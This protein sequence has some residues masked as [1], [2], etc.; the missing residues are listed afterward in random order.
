MEASV[1]LAKIKMIEDGI[2]PAMTAA[3]L[4]IMLSEMNEQEKKIAKRK[5]RKIWRKIAKNP[6]YARSMSLGTKDPDRNIKANRAAIVAIHYAR[7][8]KINP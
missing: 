4:S 5:F 8:Q 6:S 3:E 2:I 7:S 1:I